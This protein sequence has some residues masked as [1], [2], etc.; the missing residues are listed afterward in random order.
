[1]KKGKW[2]R[3]F[4]EK[5]SGRIHSYVN[6][7]VCVWL[8]EITLGECLKEFMCMCVCVCVCVC[9]CLLPDTIKVL[10]IHLSFT[11]TK[12]ALIKKYTNCKKN[13]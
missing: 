12:N 9:V 2:E 8:E 1:M 7:C 11:G 5:G 10:K 13:E 3:K 6:V 4:D